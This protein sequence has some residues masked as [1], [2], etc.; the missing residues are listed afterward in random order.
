MEMN[1]E[2]VK[3]ESIK[4]W[5]TFLALPEVDE[6]LINIGTIKGSQFKRPLFE[7]NNFV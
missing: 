6:S 2:E 5:K 1:T 4:T 3:E 7:R